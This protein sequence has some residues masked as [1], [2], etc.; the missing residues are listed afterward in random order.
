MKK[1]C[2]WWTVRQQCAVHDWLNWWRGLAATCV[3]QLVQKN[4][5]VTR[6]IRHNQSARKECQGEKMSTPISLQALTTPFELILRYG[7][8]WNFL[9]RKNLN[10]E[11]LINPFLQKASIYHFCC[12]KEKKIIPKEQNLFLKIKRFLSKFFFM[13]HI[14]NILS[15]LIVLISNKNIRDWRIYRI[16][17][18]ERVEYENTGG[19]WILRVHQ[20]F[21]NW[22][23]HEIVR[24]Y[25]GWSIR[26]TI[27][28]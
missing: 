28:P 9:P 5:L 8:S 25:V 2:D 3:Q 7:S 19:S 13:T 22:S 21:M 1:W 17:E 14:L 26:R 20:I 16:I 18:H 23:S 11:K 15:N 24:T 4:V 10:H 27:S 6:A 12:V